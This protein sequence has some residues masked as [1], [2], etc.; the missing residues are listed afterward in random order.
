MFVDPPVIRCFL[1]AS[2]SLMARIA[3]LESLLG[4]TCCLPQGAVM[5]YNLLHYSRFARSSSGTVRRDAAGALLS[6]MAVGD[7]GC[8]GAARSMLLVAVPGL[9]GIEGMTA[10]CTLGGITAAVVEDT[11]QWRCSAGSPHHQRYSR[12]RQ[13]VIG[14]IVSLL[15]N[16]GCAVTLRIKARCSWHCSMVA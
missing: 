7:V 8:S 5:T 16:P 3:K 2:L 4:V 12:I 14:S 11:R 1:G 6:T 13:S 15:G 9:G 10:R